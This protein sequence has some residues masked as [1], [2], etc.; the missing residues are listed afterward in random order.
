LI[1][2]RM[3]TFESCEAWGV[4]MD[5]LKEPGAEQRLLHAVRTALETGNVG[6]EAEARMALGIFWQHSRKN[7]E[8]KR[9]I[10]K[11]MAL[12]VASETDRQCGESYLKAIEL[13]YQDGSFME[14]SQVALSIKHYVMSRLPEGL[15]SE[16][17]VTV[18]PKGGVRTQ[19]EVD[20]DLSEEEVALVHSTIDE[21]VR[22]HDDSVKAEVTAV[23]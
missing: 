14:S 15:I 4:A 8:A 5:L 6:L 19:V 20:R 9:E 21:A 16:L 7:G 23:S 3:S 13:G 22:L 12:G 1:N 18:D 10:E 11:A 17:V 2:T